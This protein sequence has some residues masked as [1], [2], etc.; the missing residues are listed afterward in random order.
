MAFQPLHS[1]IL[2]ASGS[3]HFDEGITE[4]YSD[5]SDSE[6]SADQDSDSESQNATVSRRRPHPYVRDSSLKLW[7]FDPTRLRAGH[8]T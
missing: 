1:N 7:S 4:G 5:G 8:H 3:R 2:S 6:H